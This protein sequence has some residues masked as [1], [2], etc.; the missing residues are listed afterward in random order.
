MSKRHNIWSLEVLSRN[1]QF[2]STNIRASRLPADKARSLGLG[3][4]YRGRFLA[5]GFAALRRMGDV[6]SS[7][8]AGLVASQV[9]IEIHPFHSGGK[10]VFV[11][12]AVTVISSAIANR[13]VGFEQRRSG[14]LRDCLYSTL[15]AVSFGSVVAVASLA[16]T[17][18]PPT[19]VWLWTAVWAFVAGSLRLGA[20]VFAERVTRSL[21]KHDMSVR[22]VAVLGTGNDAAA[23]A[24]RL[25][26][27]T[28]D[29]TRFI[30]LYSDEPESDYVTTAASGVPIM[31]HVRDLIERSRWTRVDAV[32]LALPPGDIE[33]ISRARNNLRS[34]AIDIYVAAELLELSC[35]SHDDRNIKRLGGCAVLQINIPPLT[36]AQEAWK[37]TFD[38]VAAGLILVMA[39]P[40]MILIAIAIKLDSPGPVFFRQPRRGLNSSIFSIFKFRTM[41]D[42]LADLKADTQT[43]RGDPR[44]T[45]VGRWL[46]KTSLDELPQLLNVLNGEMSLVGPRPHAPNTKAGGQYFHDAVNNYSLR[47]RIRPGITGWAQVSGW[48]GETKT[49]EHIE[50]RVAH[51]LHYIENW[52]FLLDLKI[53][54]LTAFRGFVNNS[55][56]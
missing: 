38:F 4:V 30:G 33:R 17:A 19:T 27:G 35:S 23:C 34:L 41:H 1:R 48:R 12:V 40:L 26:E 10:L 18:S 51:D 43:S 39:L 47:Y 45:R 14:W 46:R 15:L 53:L 32:V 29:P 5:Y 8:L 7:F 31:G 22:C 2:S 37:S 24:A 28:D 20:T 25:M 16:V 13:T 49:R 11:T 55:A 6:F 21:I 44:V 9:C 50:Q 56:F 42:H 52:S 3:N 36:K 54:V